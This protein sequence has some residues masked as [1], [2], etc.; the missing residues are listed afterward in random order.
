[1]PF[2]SA[3]QRKYVMAQLRN[4]SSKLSRFKR[5]VKDVKKEEGQRYGYEKYSPY[6]VCRAST[7]Y[8]GT[9]RNIGLKHPVDTRIRAYR[10]REKYMTKREHKAYKKYLKKA[11]SGKYNIRPNKRKIAKLIQK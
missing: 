8:K 9:S 10:K 4:K 1:M 2:K 7:G 3:R 11:Y 6:A 5:C